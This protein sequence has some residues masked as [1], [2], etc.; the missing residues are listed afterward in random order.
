MHVVQDRT[1]PDIHLSSRAPPPPPGIK[2]WRQT[3]AIINHKRL[4]QH[5]L[6]KEER[7][8]LLK[9][10]NYFCHE[11]EEILFFFPSIRGSSTVLRVGANY[12][13]TPRK[14]Q[15][16]PKTIFV[17]PFIV[18]WILWDL[19][20][21]TNLPLLFFGGK[22]F[23][24]NIFWSDT[25]WLISE[26]LYRYIFHNQSSAICPK[27]FIITVLNVGY[28]YYETATNKLNWNLASIL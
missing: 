2:T 25:E 28:I 5:R 4:Y 10:I 16:C 8:S 15:F 11:K 22:N 26:E 7:S 9:V 19:F 27:C 6:V 21:I 20:N 3:P 12:N 23:V 13:T 1:P 17:S 14:H 24:A 18:G